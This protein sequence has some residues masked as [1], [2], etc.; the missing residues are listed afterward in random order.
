L[1]L[2]PLNPAEVATAL[3]LP[4]A[5]AVDAHLVSGG[6]P[7]VIRSW[8]SGTPAMDFLR[9]ECEDPTA[10]V[11]SIP[12]ASLQAEFPSPGLSRQVLEA[13]GPGNRTLANIATAAGGQ[14]RPLAS[15][16][17]SPLLRRLVDDKR[18]LTAQVPLSTRPGRS[19][20]PALYR[21]ADSNLRLYLAV[22]EAHELSRRG[23]PDAAFALIER[24][25]S[26][27]RGSSVEP[28]V[29]ESLEMA[30]GARALPW[31]DVGVV[32]AWWD[33]TFSVEVDLVG[34]D[35]VPGA[36][37]ISFVGSVKWRVTPVDRRDVEELRRSAAQ[38]PGADPATCGLV[39]A[40][41]AGRAKEVD[42][43]SVD[44]WWGP[45]DIIRAWS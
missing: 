28:L 6:L 12:E 43:E 30:A 8:Q 26:S 42:P 5:D 22:R 21:V 45:G 4:P 14:Q 11:F 38:V 23:R 20:R 3:S 1:V 34:A 2:G 31:A 35:R 9:S 44:L 39:L 41:L 17:L 16:T 40:S 32:G 25:W 7:G 15:G 33:R 10:S 36:N 13:V 37:V 24:R 19:A 27:W 18:L 29:R